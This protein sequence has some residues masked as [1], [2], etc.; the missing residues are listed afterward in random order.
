MSWGCGKGPKF[1]ADVF[2]S[3]A[4]PDEARVQPIAERLNSLGYSVWRQAG[5]R[6]DRSHTDLLERE[7]ESAKAVLTVWSNRARNATWVYAASALA[8]EDEKLVQVR[9]DDVRLP[10]P[11]DALQCADIGAGQSGWGKLEDAL[12]RLVREQ[13]AP[14]PIERVRARR[15]LALPAACGAAPAVTV[16]TAMIL[17]A[18]PLLNALA[19]NAALSPDQLQWAAAGILSLAC[20]CIA[21]SAHRYWSIRR[22]GG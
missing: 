15:G 17:A 3:Y 6:F 1:L 20:L 11:F 14:E 10:Q 18:I 21:F 16:I 22:A 12:A 9:L 5:G 13:R 4:R 7:M 19:L 8:L 2:I